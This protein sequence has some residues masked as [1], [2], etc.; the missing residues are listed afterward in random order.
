MSEPSIKEVGV[1]QASGFDGGRL[2]KQKDSS[3]PG[4]SGSCQGTGCHVGCP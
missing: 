2:R 4:E 1:C 3:N